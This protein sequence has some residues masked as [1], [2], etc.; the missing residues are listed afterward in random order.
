MPFGEE[1]PFDATYRT[2]DRKYGAVDHVRQKFT[3]Y[4]RD[5]ES[6]LDFAEARYYNMNH[7][8]FTAVD[9]LLAS[10]KSAD[11]QTFNRYAYSIN[12][13]LVLTDPTGE[14]CGKEPIEDDGT[15]EAEGVQVNTLVVGVEKENALAIK[16]A[17][18]LNAAH[19]KEQGIIK[20]AA[21]NQRS[22][23]KKALI[24]DFAESF[25]PTISVSAGLTGPTGGVTINMPSPARPLEAF[26]LSPVDTQS[27]IALNRID[28]EVQVNTSLA[29]ASVDYQVRKIEPEEIKRSLTVSAE[30]AIKMHRIAVNSSPRYKP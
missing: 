9:P 3:G 15:E 28:A 19:F 24:K 27:Q 23:V 12:R 14:Q 26:F 13:P 5:E 20:A 16:I 21:I 10:G 25:D 1:L 7:G 6:G 4:P 30:L 29:D 8:R 18:Q 2:A 17:Q 22:E 11:P